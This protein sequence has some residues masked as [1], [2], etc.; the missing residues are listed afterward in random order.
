MLTNYTIDNEIKSQ[1]I[2]NIYND[3]NDNLLFGMA[4]VGIY[5]FNGNSFDKKF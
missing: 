5:N 3:N 1:M 2:W 4:D